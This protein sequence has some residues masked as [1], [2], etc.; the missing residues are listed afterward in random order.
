MYDKVRITFEK[1][2]QEIVKGE[3]LAREDADLTAEYLIQNFWTMHKA[4]SPARPHPTGSC[5]KCG[6]PYTWHID[7]DCPTRAK[8][9]Q[10]N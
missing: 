2:R 3:V 6:D 1:D 5:P 10:E 4:V 7:V 8:H 9:A